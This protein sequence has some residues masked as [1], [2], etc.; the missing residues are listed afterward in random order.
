VITKG[1]AAAIAALIGWALLSNKLRGSKTIKLI[2]FALRLLAVFWMVVSGSLLVEDAF[3]THPS[4]WTASNHAL[5]F[6]LSWLW[7]L[8]VI[9]PTPKKSKEASK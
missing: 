1:L 3:Y 9:S 7:I 4:L 2:R 5:G 6:V 8:G